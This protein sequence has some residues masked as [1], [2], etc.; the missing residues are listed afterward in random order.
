MKTIKV[1]F[2]GFYCSSHDADLD[3]ALEQEFREDDGTLT[4]DYEKA[5][6]A[7]D[8]QQVHKAYSAKYASLLSD[9][10]NLPSLKFKELISPREYNFTTDVIHCDISDEDIEKLVAETNDVEV[11][12]VARAWFT[13]RDGFISFYSPDIYDWGPVDQWD[14]NQLG[15]LLQ[16]YMNQEHPDRYGVNFSSES[17]SELTETLRCNGDLSNM[18]WKA[19]P[20]EF[21]DQI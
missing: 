16:A 3:N 20:S 2:S 10:A 6:A 7:I 1:P 13:S 18:I 9:L 12:Q 17:E 11:R 21:R 4:E 8:W 19:L 15:A 14:H 5:L